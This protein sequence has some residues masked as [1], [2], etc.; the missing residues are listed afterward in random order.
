MLAQRELREKQRSLHLVDK[1]VVDACIKVGKGVEQQVVRRGACNLGMRDSQ[2]QL[3][4]FGGAHHNGHDARYA[5]A[6]HGALL[7][8]LQHKDGRARCA[9]D[10]DLLHGDGNQACS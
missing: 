5:R 10:N 3:S 2:V 8:R 6:R 7:D 9:S 1:D 4:R